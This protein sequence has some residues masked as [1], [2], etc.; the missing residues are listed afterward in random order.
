MLLVTAAVPVEPDPSLVTPGAFGLL[1][2][3]FL[4]IAVFLLA[5]SMFRRIKRV[6]FP[7]APTDTD[8]P[9]PTRDASQ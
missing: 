2:T 8:P 1:L 7:E 6:D 5:R 4:G 3:V 9:A